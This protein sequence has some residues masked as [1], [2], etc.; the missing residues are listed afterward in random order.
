MVRPVTYTVAPAAPS[1]TAMPRPAPR[2]PPATTAT[3]SLRLLGVEVIPPLNYFTFIKS[4]ATINAMRTGRPRTVSD[5]AIFDAVRAV[6]TDVGPS[7]LTLAAVANRV[8]LSAPAL[9][10]RFGSKRNLL[11]AYNEAAATGIDD[12]FNRVRSSSS[13]ALSA[14]RATLLKLTAGIHTRHAIANHLAFLHLDLTDPELGAH[15]A[16]QSRLLRQAITRLLDEAIT[17]GEINRTATAELADTVYT[18]YNGAPRHL[19]HRRHREPHSVVVGS[20]R[21]CPRL[22][23][24]RGA[25]IEIGETPFPL[26]ALVPP[27]RRRGRPSRRWPP[28][29]SRTGHSSHELSTPSP[30]T[31][32]VATEWTRSASCATHAGS[33][34]PRNVVP[35]R[36]DNGETGRQVLDSPHCSA[37]APGIGIADVKSPRAMGPPGARIAPCR[38]QERD[39]SDGSGGWYFPE[40]LRVRAEHRTRLSS[41]RR[42]VGSWSCRGRALFRRWRRPPVRPIECDDLVRGH[43]AHSIS[44]PSVCKSRDSS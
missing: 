41:G 3:R 12:V 29:S 28:C 6:V 21:P 38:W 7:G 25:A 8:G 39:R 22:P 23:P 9:T 40:P 18:V 13:T 5:E 16:Q 35:A 1:S 27:S 32:V 44:L 15:A 17:T 26:G 19:G 33:R 34:R 20:A 42:W 30:R 4:S 11:L 37:D 2:V 36:Q 10:Q 24:T 43:R 31:S 14:L